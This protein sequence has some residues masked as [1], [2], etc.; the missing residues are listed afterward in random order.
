M[1][2]EAIIRKDM[3]L[4]NKFRIGGQSEYA[5]TMRKKLVDCLFVVDQGNL[6]S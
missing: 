3:N 5:Q 1:N 4:A 2:F 6:V